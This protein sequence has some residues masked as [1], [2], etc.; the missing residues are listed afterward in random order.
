MIFNYKKD[1]QT[2]TFCSRSSMKY[3]RY[4]IMAGLPPTSLTSYTTVA[5]S[6][7]WINIKPS[8][9]GLSTLLNKHAMGVNK[10]LSFKLL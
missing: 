4:Q 8:K 2:I 1:I 9:C 3:N 5:N 7:S 10:A 6:K